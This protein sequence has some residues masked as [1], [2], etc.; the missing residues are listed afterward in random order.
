MQARMGLQRGVA[1]LLLLLTIFFITTVA[2]KFLVPGTR[3]GRNTNF[4]AD[5]SYFWKQN[6][7]KVFDYG[8]VISLGK[9]G[10]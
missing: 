6:I 5:R 2:G 7:P 9:L 3:S 8:S 10:A 4:H 1:Q